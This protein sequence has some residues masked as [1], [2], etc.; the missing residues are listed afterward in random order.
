MLNQDRPRGLW[1]LP[2]LTGEQVEGVFEYAEGFAWFPLEQEN[3]RVYAARCPLR[4]GP[5]FPPVLQEKAVAGIEP[6][7]CQGGKQRSR[8]GRAHPCA[9][10]VRGT[11][12]EREAHRAR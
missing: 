11:L 2:V 12:H 3:R 1:Y 6:G 7:S 4:R 10:P 9:G 8:K 5:V